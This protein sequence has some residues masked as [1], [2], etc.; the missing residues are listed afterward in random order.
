M[1]ISY[2]MCSKFSVNL[3][4]NIFFLL[5]NYLFYFP[6][7]FCFCIICILYFLQAVFMDLRFS[8]CYPI[9]MYCLNNFFSFSI[10]KNGFFCIL[11][12]LCVCFFLLFEFSCY[13]Y[14]DNFSSLYYWNTLVDIFCILY[15]SF[16]LLLYWQNFWSSIYILIS[17]KDKMFFILYLS[18][19]FSV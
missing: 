18:M 6:N 5:F 9:F 16:F 11:Y 19:Y 1:C 12:F 15:F 10:F 3:K 8:L 4:I 14:S 2:L 17:S 7:N 13:V